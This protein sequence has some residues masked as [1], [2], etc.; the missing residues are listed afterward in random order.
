MGGRGGA[1]S[2]LDAAR[3]RCMTRRRATTARPPQPLVPFPPPFVPISSPSKVRRRAGVAASPPRARPRVPRGGGARP[4][5][6]GRGGGRSRGG[7]G[8]SCA[9]AADATATPPNDDGR[10]RGRRR[11]SSRRRHRRDVG[12]MRRRR[13]RVRARGAG[14]GRPRRRRRCAAAQPPSNLSCV[15]STRDTFRH[16]PGRASGRTADGS[17]ALAPLALTTVQLGASE[18]E[19]GA[20]KDEGRKAKANDTA[21]RPPTAAGGSGGFPWRVGGLGCAW[22]CCC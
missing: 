14:G 10:R 11:G 17:G 12:T 21:P 13:G 8:A 5:R 19:G 22:V 2:A 1:R 16:E 3:V 7:G 18:L 4:A 15:R 9:T 20:G 6:Q